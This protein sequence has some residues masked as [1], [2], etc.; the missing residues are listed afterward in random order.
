MF[1][2]DAVPNTSAYMV[3]GYAVFFVVMAVYLASLFIR[4]QNLQ[5][6][7]RLLEDMQ[8]ETKQQ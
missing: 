5:Q 4:W 3:A 1:F 6:D 2:Q 8:K 7:L